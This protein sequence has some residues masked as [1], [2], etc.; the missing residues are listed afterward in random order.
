MLALLALSTLLAAEPATLRGRVTDASTGKPLQGVLIVSHMQSVRCET[1]ADGTFDCGELPPN[2]YWLRWEDDSFDVIEPLELGAG[3]DHVLEL[4]FRPVP[5]GSKVRPLSFGIVR[6]LALMGGPD[7]NLYGAG[8]NLLH[9]VNAR[10]FG[11]EVGTVNETLGQARGVQIGLAFNHTVEFY[12]LQVAGF[13]NWVHNP[14]NLYGNAMGVQLCGVVCH[15]DLLVGF[16]I[17]GA[18]ALH[19][20]PYGVQ[21]AGLAAIHENAVGFF[22]TGAVNYFSDYTGGMVVSGFLNYMENHGGVQL[23]PINVAR[24]EATGLQVGVINFA[25]RLGGMQLG[26]VNI[27]LR[28]KIRVLPVANIRRAG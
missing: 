19:G 4:S 6:K 1:A 7:T 2:K 21:F 15:S 18:L 11:L 23:A 24:G 3:E 17:A 14:G 16:R 8:F 25:R 28:P 26:L 20:S 5:T 9:G 10:M 22:A 27:S 13:A 12:G